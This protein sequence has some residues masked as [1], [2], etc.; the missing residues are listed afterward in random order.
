MHA[1]YIIKLIRL[2]AKIPADLAIGD[3]DI[4]AMLNRGQIRIDSLAPNA[5]RWWFTLV[6]DDSSSRVRAVANTYS[7]DLPTG[8]RAMDVVKCLDQNSSKYNLNWTSLIE[9]D[10]K[11]ID[12]SDTGLH[13]NV[14]KAWTI[15]PPDSDN[16]VGY[17][18]VHPTPVDT[19]N[20]FYRR[21]WRYLPELTTFASETLIPLPELLFNWGMHS[22]YLLRED[23]DNALLYKGFFDEGV[24][25]LTRLQR[26]QIGQME[27]QRYRGQRGYQDL[28]GAANVGYTDDQRQYNW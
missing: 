27:F 24:T 6:E 17:F 23:T 9:F 22:I 4:L 16:L 8:F 3:L 12:D 26:R 2:Y 19:T 20:Y 18:G 11:K 14:T 7:Y 10:Q 21:Y 15:L 5:G 25:M 28:F 1:G 13:N